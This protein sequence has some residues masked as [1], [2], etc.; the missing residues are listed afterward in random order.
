MPVINQLVMLK[1]TP[2]QPLVLRGHYQNMNLIVWPMKKRL[3]HL[4]VKKRWSHWW[5]VNVLVG[6]Y[7]CVNIPFIQ[8]QN[9]SKQIFVLVWIGIVFSVGKNFVQR[10]LSR[11]EL[12][13]LWEEEEMEDDWL[14]WE[15]QKSD[16][17][18]LI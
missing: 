6:L 2:K 4:F 18:W 11:P 3:Q 8:I 13:R 1:Q 14:R 16:Y 10:C 12:Q 9:L 17:K 5:Y 15:W 7:R